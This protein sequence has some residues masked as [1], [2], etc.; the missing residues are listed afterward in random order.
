VRDHFLT[1]CTGGRVPSLD[2][3]EVHVWYA[4]VD[5]GKRS[6]LLSAPEA[7]LSAEERGRLDRCRC[8]EQRQHYILARA[9][10]RRTLSRYVDVPPRSWTI[11]SDQA[12]RP[13]VTAPRLDPR[14]SFSVSHTPGLVVCAVAVDRK[15]GV[16][17]EDLERNLFSGERQAQIAERFFSAR[18]ARSL[19]ALAPAARCDRFFMYWTLKESYAKALGAGLRIPP[20]RYAFSIDDRGRIDCRVEPDLAYDPQRWQFELFRPSLRHLVAVSVERRRTETLRVQIR[21]SPVR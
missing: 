9:L 8:P 18:E 17:A 10:V 15:I 21:T 1:A 3:S 2:V 19:R 16:D 5:A 4:L 12:G 6:D 20:D 7:L 13:E 11:V 14:L